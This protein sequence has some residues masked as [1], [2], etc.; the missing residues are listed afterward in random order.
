MTTIK[1]S[2]HHSLSRR[3][4]VVALLAA[5]ALPLGNEIA[6]AADQ[7][8]LRVGDQKGGNRSLL[9]IS[10]LTHDH[11]YKIEWSEFPAAFL[12]ADALFV[13]VCSLRDLVT[14]R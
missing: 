8:V 4:L 6:Q 14:Q 2:T 9:E 10:G 13:L 12:V 3:S 7:I 5:A 1:N 11:S